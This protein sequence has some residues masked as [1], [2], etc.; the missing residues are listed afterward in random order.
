MRKL[1]TVTNFRTRSAHT[2]V[3]TPSETLTRRHLRFCLWL[4]AAASCL[5]AQSPDNLRCEYQTQ[6]IAIQTLNPRFSWLLT[7][8]ENRHNI[9]QTAYRVI[10]SSDK[11]SI[12]HHLG[13]Q[14]DSGKTNSS[15]TL[16]VTYAG[17]DLTSSNLYYWAVETWDETGSTH[18]SSP[19]TFRTALLSQRD[20][21]A[22]WIMAADSPEREPALPLLRREFKLTKP[23]SQAIVYISG[24]GQYELHLNGEKV[25]NDQLAPGWTDYRKTVLYNSY[26]ITSALHKG[27]NIFGVML[28]NGMYNVPD[29]K[30]RYTKFN[31]TFGPPKLLFQAQITFTDGTT[32]RIQSDHTWRTIQ[33]PITFSNTYGG[34][35]YDAR[36]EQPG[37]DR[38]GFKEKDWL[39]AQETE[40]P[41]GK[42]IAQQS[43][44][45]QVAQ[46]LKPI[47][48]TEPKPGVFVYDLGRNFS[49]WPEIT[50]NGPRG[51]SVKLISGELL[52]R[53]GL[54]S[55]RSSGGPQWY[56]YTLGGHGTQTW[57]PRFSYWGFRYVQVERTPDAGVLPEVISL[58]GQFIHAAAPATGEF[59][60]SSDLLNRTHALIDAAIQSNLQSIL[61]DCPHREKL[62][63]LEQTHLIGSALMY[64]FDLATFYEKISNDMAD[65]QNTD[66][67][68]PDIAPEFVVFERG[69][70][71]S[72]E[73]GSA[74]ILDPWL[75]YKKYGD[76]G[77][78][79]AHYEA[80]KRY[81][82]YLDS[83]AEGNIISYGLG[84][85]Y[86]IGPGEPGE[87]KLTSLGVTATATYYQDLI[88]LAE[89]ARVLHKPQEE[90]AFRNH[91]AA[92]RQ[93]FNQRFYTAETHVYDK[94]SQTAYAMALAT[95]L[96]PDQ[97]R[98]F[99]LQKLVADIKAHD[100]HVTAGDIGFHYVV[101]ALME[102]GRSD[103]LFD[104]LSR[105]DSPSYG[106][107]LKKGATTLT[108]AWDANPLDSQNHFM[109]G[110]AEEWFY[111][112]L[113]GIDFDLSRPEG[114]QLIIK[115]SPVGNLTSAAAT[116][117]S[118]L[119]K[120]TSQ[121][122][123]SAGVFKLTVDIPPNLT[124]IIKLPGGVTA[125]VGSGHYVFPSTTDK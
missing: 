101:E 64:D 22:T 90:A 4:L 75:A 118:V 33:G 84:D 49:G 94:G 23:V 71:D 83:K 29:T 1:G 107:Q 111:R 103:V 25:S 116:Y 87:S 93:S 89:S 55:Q 119:G 115:P 15:N 46:I 32:L 95:G 112:G 3:F 37:W 42:L 121:W 9:H 56:T 82:S 41:G 100:N 30:E 122:T 62:G 105:T 65:A 104:M 58:N 21:S 31:G 2:C 52:D 16:Q 6:P 69:F 117:S 81:A 54:T 40:G 79:A 86:D 14:W 61:T 80:M 8:S 120:I 48:V 20:W 24:L 59:E 5:L 39:E 125:T 106:Y 98:P 34:E 43:P 74:F 11:K 12:T 68:I 73:W 60:T 45:I 102:N 38:P 109:L 53:D 123:N 113:A 88:T 17:K 13:D 114:H 110:H 99:I 50:V 91:A 96:A 66:G 18:W 44:T 124:A 47:K 26:D 57:H 28:G 85:W 76:T 108:E 19:S 70:L 97:D 51:S 27:D 78:I 63:W 67:L 7:A 72:P 10:V 92:V 36:L 35:D 77:I